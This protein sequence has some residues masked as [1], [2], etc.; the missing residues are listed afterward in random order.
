M[1]RHSAFASKLPQAS[2]T[3]RAEKRL[4]DHF[5]T[6]LVLALTLGLGVLAVTGAVLAFAGLR[7]DV[8]AISL[9]ASG[10]AVLRFITRLGRESDRAAL[11]F[12]RYAILETVY[13]VTGFAAG[14]GLLV[15]ALGSGLTMR[16][17][18]RV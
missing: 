11:A 15:G 5:A 12:G 4:A 3:A 14:V 6:L 8:A 2:T 9:F 10:A 16:R 18:L 1:A 13:L 7:D 17:Y